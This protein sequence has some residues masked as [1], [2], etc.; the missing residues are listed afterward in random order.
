L[1]SLVKGVETRSGMGVDA[2]IG[3]SLPAQVIHAEDE[4]TMLE[5][6]RGVPRVKGMTVTEH[7]L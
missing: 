6:I 2:K 7:T 3:D 1:E 5:N 4:D